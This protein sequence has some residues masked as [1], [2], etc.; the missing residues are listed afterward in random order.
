MLLLQQTEL[1]T[2]PLPLITAARPSR[3]DQPSTPTVLS[4]PCCQTKL[5][6]LPAGFAAD[7]AY[8]Y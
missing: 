3:G 5:A 4:L 7:A 1:R 2:L 6:V 8:C